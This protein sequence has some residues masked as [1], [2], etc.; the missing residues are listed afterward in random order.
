MASERRISGAKTIVS[1][2]T[3][4]LKK[5]LIGRVAKLLVD[6]C[7]SLPPWKLGDESKK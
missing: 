4:D 2:S 6:R 3:K 5:C 7:I 1:A